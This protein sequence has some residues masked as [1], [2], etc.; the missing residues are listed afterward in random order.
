MSGTLIIRGQSV[1]IHGN[2]VFRHRGKMAVGE[3]GVMLPQAKEYLRLL[4][5]GK[6]KEEPFPRSF[7]RS[8][9]LPTP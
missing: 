9:V 5:A 4:E 7:R 1:D 2:A 3:T 8:M 6:D